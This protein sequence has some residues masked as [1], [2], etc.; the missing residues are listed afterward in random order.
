[1][2]KIKSPVKNRYKQA[3]K[4]IEEAKMDYYLVQEKSYFDDDVEVKCW[5]YGKK[6]F[7]RPYYPR[8]AKIVCVQCMGKLAKKVEEK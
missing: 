2:E 6:C 7:C 8:N 3:R 4:D 5:K 1:M